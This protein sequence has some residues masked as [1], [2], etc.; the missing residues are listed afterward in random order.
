MR[1]STPHFRSTT[2]NPVD[3][4]Y[5]LVC[6]GLH[7][8]SETRL[9]AVYWGHTS[10]GLWFV[11]GWQPPCRGSVVIPKGFPR[12]VGT[13]VNRSLVFHRFHQRRHFRGPG[14]FARILPV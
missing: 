6:P 5:A 12:P 7:P 2:S 4:N 13:V 10:A 8:L 11:I 9:K 3:P 14:C 1:K